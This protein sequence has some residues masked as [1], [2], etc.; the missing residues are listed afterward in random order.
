LTQICD[1]WFENIPSGNPAF[2]A[3]IMFVV[4][5]VVVNVSSSAGFLLL[6]KDGRQQ[7]YVAFKLVLKYFRLVFLISLKRCSPLF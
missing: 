6:G 2:N 7:I 4:A 5:D 1:F 3:P